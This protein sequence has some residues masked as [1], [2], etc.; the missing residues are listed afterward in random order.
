LIWE[1]GFH[2]GQLRSHV[3]PDVLP[4]IEAWR[5]AGKDVRIYSSGSIAAQKRFVGHVAEFGNCLPLVSGHYDTTIGSKREAASYTR[6]A[7]EWGISSGQIAF[8]S[9]LEPE[10]VAASAAGVQAIASIRPGNAPLSAS[11][12]WPQIQSFDQ[13]TLPRS[14]GN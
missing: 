4:A 1:S 3:Y 10:L 9:D 11:A 2:S 13:L 8:I 12:P 14:S 7:D 5:A 6:I